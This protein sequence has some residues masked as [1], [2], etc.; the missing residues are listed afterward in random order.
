MQVAA[1]LESLGDLLCSQDRQSEALPLIQH[2][3][4]IRA[5]GAGLDN[6]D[7]AWTISQL[8][9]CNLDLKNYQEADN[10]YKKAI[11]IYE[12]LDGDGFSESQ[13]IA[14]ENLANSYRWQSRYKEAMDSE[15]SLLDELEKKHLGYSY[16]AASALTSAASTA[17]SEKDSNKM[18]E[19]L[20]RAEKNRRPFGSS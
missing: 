17:Q 14:R 9:H 7:T 18:R 20:A 4:E 16:Y 11:A 10:L 1:A 5:A 2:A 3:Y 6:G 8:A 13:Q 19:Y 12:K 15:I